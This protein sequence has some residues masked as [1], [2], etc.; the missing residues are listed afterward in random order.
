[1][2]VPCL[3]EGSTPSSSTGLIGLVG[4]VGLD[5]ILFSATFALLLTNLYGWLLKRYYVPAPFKEKFEKLFPAHKM[6][7]TFYLLHLYEIPYL[8]NIGEP[9]TLFYVNGTAVMFFSSF[10]YVMVKGYFFLDEFS[11][12]RMFV[13]MLPVVMCWLV[14]LLPVLGV[15]EFSD[16]FKIVMFSAVSLVSASYIFFLVHFRNRIH[17]IISKIE[18][19]EYSNE[20][21]F[22]LKFAKRI[23]WLPLS[24]C[25]LMY[26]C[27]VI[28]HP[29]AKLMRDLI[30]IVANVWFVFYTLNP[31]RTV[32]PEVAK[33]VD[34]EMEAEDENKQQKW[35]LSEKKCRDIEERMMTLLNTEKLYL[36]DH[37]TM[38]EL[39]HKMGVNRSYVGEVISRGSYESFYRLINTLRVEQACRLL[40]DDSHGKMEQVAL[41][42]GFSS[43]SAFSQVF[44]KIKGVTPREFI[45]NK[46]SI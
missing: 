1:M 12:K 44:K 7:A 3:D 11:P 22:S 10:T 24:V 14:L 46:N 28:D 21:D 8:F 20:S 17:R 39:A 18:E 43:G 15:I 40:S 45:E 23:E 41:E 37:F 25:A 2:I 26:A 29:V 16:T 13:F 5:L 34:D 4:L 35:H 19:D 27:F 38:S 32:R 33:A 42:S 30:C 9:A 6:V 31:H 36:S